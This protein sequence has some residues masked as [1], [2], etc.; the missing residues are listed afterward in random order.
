MPFCDSHS[1]HELCHTFPAMMDC[2]FLNCKSKMSFPLQV[3]ISDASSQTSKK[4]SIE[5]SI[6]QNSKSKPVTL[7]YSDG[8]AVL[9]LQ[10]LDV[11]PQ[12]QQMWN[13]RATDSG[14]D[15][16]SQYMKRARPSQI[17][18]AFILSTF[19]SI[20]LCLNGQI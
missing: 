11:E 7:N 5:N 15:K 6:I 4:K 18:L 8:V 1:H 19:V 17:S 14:T 13:S 2:S 12:H 16:S 9:S 20:E 10:M 3:L